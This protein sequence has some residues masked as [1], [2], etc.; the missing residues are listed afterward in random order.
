M[1]EPTLIVV[2]GEILEEEWVPL[3]GFPEHSISNYG[4]VASHRYDI[5]LNPR[6]SGWGYL[7]VVLY[8]DGRHVSKTIHHMVAEHFVPGWDV[9]LIADHINGDKMFNCEVNLEWI[10]RGENNRRA[11]VLGLRKPFT[12]PVQIVETG[13]IFNSVKACAEHLGTRPGAICEVLKGRRPHYKRLTF[14]YL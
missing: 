6:P 13:E 11:V 4:R 7:Q 8:K 5:A 12:K 2:D 10:T 9:G 14:E 3:K 1:T